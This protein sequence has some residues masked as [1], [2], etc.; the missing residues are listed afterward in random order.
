M[1]VIVIIRHVSCDYMSVSR[2][3]PPGSAVWLQSGV[4][5]AIKKNAQSSK[6]RRRCRPS[7][8]E[9]RGQK[10]P[11]W[12]NVTQELEDR[13]VSVRGKTSGAMKEHRGERK[14]F[15]L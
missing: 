9:Q 14:T 5:P 6:M 10:I 11:E 8:R 1:T 12:K 3:A 13:C 4:S 15:L 7:L 2:T